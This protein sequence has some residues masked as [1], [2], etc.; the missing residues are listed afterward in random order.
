MRR[1][2]N[3]AGAIAV[4]LLA[5][6]AIAVADRK[7]AAATSIVLGKT[8]EYPESGC[9]VPD[10]CEVVARVTGIQMMADGVAHPFRAPADGQ[11]VSWWLKL[12]RLHST[13]I[14]SFNTLFGGDPSAR[15]AILRRGKQGRFRLVR[16]SDTVA[17]K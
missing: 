11:L 7:P 10:K 12:P 6:A 5:A 2:L 9:P 14:R 16:E 1:M 13:Q 17:L 3:L 4:L 15:V 8:A